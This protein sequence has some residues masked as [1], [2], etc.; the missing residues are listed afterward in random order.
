MPLLRIGRGLRAG[1]GPGYLGGMR[2]ARCG[3]RWCSPSCSRRA[4]RAPRRRRTRR[5]P[6]TLAAPAARAT[7][8]ATTARSATAPSGARR[9]APP[10]TRSAVSPGHLRAPPRSSATRRETSARARARSRPTPT[11]TASSRGRAAA[12]TATTRTRRGSRQPRACD[13]EDRDEDCDPATFGEVDADGDGAFDAAC[14]NGT[15]CGDD[16]DDTRASVNRSAG[17]VCDARDEDCD[18]AID[19]NARSDL[20]SRPRRRRLRDRDRHGVRVLRAGRLRESSP[21]TATTHGAR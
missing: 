3:T 16:C 21:A 20:L 6:S 9:R 17:E 8:C 14:C 1:P 10:P 7:T 4:A 12:T 11:V 15:V 2:E 19:E 5:P 18:G 13:A